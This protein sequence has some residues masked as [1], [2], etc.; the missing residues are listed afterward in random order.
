MSTF[1]VDYENV[2]ERGLKGLYALTNND[3]LIIF[4][5]SVC[6][7]IRNE[8]LIEIEN[9]KCIFNV[10]KLVKTGK[11]S[12]DFYIAATTGEKVSNNEKEIAIISND[13]GFQSIVDYY[14]QNKL[15]RVIKA[16][17]IERAIIAFGNSSGSAKR[18]LVK[19]FSQEKDLDLFIIR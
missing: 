9:S 16:S 8:D 5:S 7:K 18:N 2:R 3:T 13:N 11:N 4:Y 10:V 14:R 1:L 12:L 6:K 17:T 15:S 19:L